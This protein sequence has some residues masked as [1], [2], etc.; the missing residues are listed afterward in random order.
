MAVRR[1]AGHAPA[2][3]GAASPR[4]RSALLP[5]ALVALYYARALGLDPLEQAWMALLSAASG[6]LSLAVAVV[7]AA[8]LAC[9]AGAARRSCARAGASRRTPSPSRCARA[10]R[11][12]TPA[13]ARSAARSPRCGDDHRRAAPVAT[14]RALR[15]LSTV[16]IVAGV[17]LLADAALTLLWQEPVSALYAHVQQGKLDDQL[18]RARAG[19]AR[20]RPSSARSRRSRTRTRRL[21]FRARALERRLEPG[22]PIGPDRDPGDRRLGRVRR[23]APAPATCARARATI[24][25]RRCRASAARSR[26]P[27]TARPTARR[28]AT[29]TSSIRGDRIELRMP[30]GRFTYRVERTKIVPP[31]GPVGDRPRRSTTGSCSPPAIRS[32]RAAQRIIVF[33]RLDSSVPR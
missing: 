23:R 5:F 15:A 9:L 7:A 32:T 12:P 3:L 30:Y 13:P 10:A 14:R 16:L 2:R 26:S 27:A 21:A 31:D 11:P 22:D 6:Q 18:V 24:R 33:A 8:L 4:S 17:I 25:R 20:R 29:S 19:A 1:R 28:S